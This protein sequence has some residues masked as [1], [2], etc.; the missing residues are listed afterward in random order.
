MKETLATVNPNS[1]EYWGNN[2]LSPNDYKK[3]SGATVEWKC[4]KCSFTW[5]K[6]ISEWTKYPNCNACITA[7]KSKVIEGTNDLVTSNKEIVEELWDYEKN[8]IP[9]RNYTNTSRTKVYWK[10]LEGKASINKV[11]K[12][13]QKKEAITEKENSLSKLYPELIEWFSK[14]DDSLLTVGSNKIT[15]FT[16]LEHGH[17]WNSTIR[18]F[19]KKK[20]KCPYCSFGKLLQGFND[21]STTH[22]DLAKELIS[23][24]PKKTMKSCNSIG[25]WKCSKCNQT[26]KKNIAERIKHDSNCP[27]CSNKLLLTGV[28][29]LETAVPDIQAILSK[30]NASDPSTIIAGSEKTLIVKC[31]CDND[32]TLPAYYIARL[33]RKG[34]TPQCYSCR[35]TRG[36]QAIRKILED[37]GIQFLQN[38]RKTIDGEL[39]FYIPDK[40]IAIEFNGVYWHS[41]VFKSKDYHY[42]KWLS[43]K[44]EN[45]QLFSIWEDE[46]ENVDLLKSTIKHKLGK[47]N[48]ERVGARTLHFTILNNSE[49]KEFLEQYHLQGF[50]RSS[51]Y[52]GLVD[53][54][55]KLIAVMTFKKNSKKGKP[56]ILTRY[57]TS[58]TVAGGFTKL[59]SNSVKR[60]SYTGIIRTFASHDISNG[61][62]YLKNGFKNVGT[63]P[64]DYSYVINGKR[65]HKSNYRKKRFY[66]DPLL[67]FQEG[68]TEKELAKL[69]EINRVWD[70]GKTIFEIDVS[71]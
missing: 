42:N 28:N 63:I 44:N 67:K 34:L 69:N 57:A 16:C 6:K 54:N 36:E 68:L 3:S 2:E 61:D 49:A 32:I 27:Y 33:H 30:N 50:V 46:I 37:S 19:L 21:I 48:N 25:T 5:N 60:M 65:I 1:I 29:D 53:K 4:P 55:G 13:N 38:E 9:P 47:S 14:K 64:P 20:D 70:C 51:H 23:N 22:P 17:K 52:F 12:D 45:I 58:K 59:L 39:D 31:A 15:E 56:L 26:W 18:N 10:H 7:K 62:L 24:N 71:E 8:S 43:C 41:E 35:E 66:S 40:K 11:I